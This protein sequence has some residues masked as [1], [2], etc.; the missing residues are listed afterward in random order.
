MTEDTPM[1]LEIPSV[2]GALC[3]EPET[4]TRQFFTI[5]YLLTSISAYTK[6][7]DIVL[8]TTT[9]MFKKVINTLDLTKI[10]FYSMLF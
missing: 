10:K 8:L 6:Y 9:L 7:N 2:L 5:E 1:T 3:Q 4:K